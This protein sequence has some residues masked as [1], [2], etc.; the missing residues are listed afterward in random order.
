MTLC[1]PLSLSQSNGLPQHIKIV[2]SRDTI[3]E[4]SFAQV[5]VLALA[6]C[7]GHYPLK[8]NNEFDLHAYVWY[9]PIVK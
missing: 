1:S 2:V 3:F 9:V 8:L 7:E 5:Q 4:D 6:S